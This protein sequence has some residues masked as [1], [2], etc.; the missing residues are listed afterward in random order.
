MIG[1]RRQ[2]RHHVDSSLDVVLAQPSERA[3][4]RLGRRRARLDAARELAVE[5][6]QRQVN[7]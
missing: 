7:R 3:Q 5:R 4:A 6:D 2:H 1:D